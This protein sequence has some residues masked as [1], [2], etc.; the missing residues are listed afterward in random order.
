MIKTFEQ[1]KRIQQNRIA[2]NKPG[3]ATAVKRFINRVG[4]NGDNCPG[5]LP[6]IS[7]IQ[8]VFNIYDYCAD[9]GFSYRTDSKFGICV[10]NRKFL[11]IGKAN[12]LINFGGYYGK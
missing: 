9:N 3:F 8:A 10:K 4:I 5:G 11:T 12:R 7:S 6:S 2:K 1:A